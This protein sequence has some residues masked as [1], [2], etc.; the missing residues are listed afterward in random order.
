MHSLYRIINSNYGDKNDFKSS[1]AQSQQS[2][3]V[4]NKK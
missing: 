3:L 2:I 1:G 4:A